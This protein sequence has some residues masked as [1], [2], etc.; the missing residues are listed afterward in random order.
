MGCGRDREGVASTQKHWRRDGRLTAESCLHVSMTVLFHCDMSEVLRASCEPKMRDF[1]RF[2]GGLFFSEGFAS[3]RR[4]AS[5]ASMNQ[6]VAG[7]VNPFPTPEHFVRAQSKR[8][9][10]RPPSCLAPLAPRG[11]PGRVRTARASSTGP[12]VARKV[13]EAVLSDFGPATCQPRK[14]SKKP[15]SNAKH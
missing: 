10:F 6:S 12:T 11:Q 14:S 15:F 4:K 5:R 1:E 7:R 3:D 2:W 13:R 9:V 8:P